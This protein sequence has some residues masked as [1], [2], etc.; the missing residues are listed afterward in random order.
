M[1]KHDE[2]G[3]KV[4]YLLLD[5]PKVEGDENVFFDKM[6]SFLD[7]ENFGLILEVRGKK[8][9]SPEAKKRLGHWFKENKGTLKT[10]CCGFARVNQNLGT[11]EKLRSKAMSLAMPCPY[12]VCSSLDEAL[13]WFQRK[14]G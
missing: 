11:K 9:F 13:S 3:S 4:H 5:E 14:Q 6:N 2:L 12:L 8:A 1:I 10:K 7:Q